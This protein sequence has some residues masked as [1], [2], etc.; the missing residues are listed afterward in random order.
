MA[1]NRN[2]L[3]S[4]IV[5]SLGGVPSGLTRNELLA[6]W[7]EA[8]GASPW[9]PADITTELWL[10]AS[11]TST[12]TES[13]VLVSEWRDKSGSGNDASQAVAASQPVYGTRTQNGLNVVDF[14]NDWM[15]APLDYSR[16]TLPNVSIFAVFKNDSTSNSAALFGNDNGGYD[17]FVL[18]NFNSA[19]N[20]QWGIG[21]GS[22][23]YPLN[24]FRTVD[25][26]P[27]ILRLQVQNG[28]N[29]GSQVALDGVATSSYTETN[30]G[31]MLTSL[32]I[33]SIDDTGNY[34][35][36]GAI[37]EIMFIGE[38]VTDD[39]AKRAEGYLAHKWGLESLLP[40]GH[41]YKTS[42]P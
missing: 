6:E 34:S 42:P 32:G 38:N 13:L 7:L 10:D 20:I 19:P 16:T 4:D 12:I 8:A 31:T 21:T 41:P 40:V 2:E 9:T 37:A 5:I 15:F 26:N 30:N 28:V 24:P 29:N 11:D 35:L 14:Q 39:T 1:K 17:R 23:V 18:M 33:G 22:T 25:T 3:I 27:H 36:D